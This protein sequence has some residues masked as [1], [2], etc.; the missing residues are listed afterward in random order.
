MK[1]TQT[2]KLCSRI[3]KLVVWPLPLH[4][5]RYYLSVL[6]M[7]STLPLRSDGPTARTPPASALSFISTR[8]LTSGTMARKSG[9]KRWRFASWRRLME[10]GHLRKKPNSPLKGW[11]RMGSLRRRCGQLTR[12]SPGRDPMCPCPHFLPST[13]TRSVSSLAQTGVHWEASSVPAENSH[14]IS[15]K[16]RCSQSQKCVHDV[17]SYCCAVSQRSWAAQCT[18]HCNLFFT[19]VNGVCTAGCRVMRPAPHNMLAGSVSACLGQMK[20]R[21]CKLVFFGLDFYCR[22]NYTLEATN[23]KDF[24]SYQMQGME[25]VLFLIIK[26]NSN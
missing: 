14:N 7:S 17:R 11:M 9:R 22:M 23:V 1:L 16:Q 15:L 26:L 6:S 5:G 13:H 12:H 8:T 10:N 18:R 20:C 19:R 2:T 4:M 21:C 3:Q 24:K 25:K